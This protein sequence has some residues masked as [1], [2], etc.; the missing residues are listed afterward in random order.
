MKGRIIY[1]EVVR[2]VAAGA[3]A[4]A[5]ICYSCGWGV[6]FAVRRSVFVIWDPLGLIIVGKEGGGSVVTKAISASA[7]LVLARVLVFG[8]CRVQE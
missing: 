6:S 8:L 7:T 1:S 3:L 2:I 5:P 4:R